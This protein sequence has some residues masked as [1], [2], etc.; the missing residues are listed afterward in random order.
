MG[1]GID[2]G[3]SGLKVVRLHRTLRGFRLIGA[4]R[5]TLPTDADL[6]SAVPQALRQILARTNPGLGVVGLGG[7][8][9]NLQIVQQPAMPAVNYRAMMGYEMEQRR[10]GEGALY[11]DFATL[12]EPD[13]YH[14]GYLAM[15]G[16]A[17]CDY[18]DQRIAMAAG[19]G[20]DVRDAI[21]TPFALYTAYRHAYGVENGIVML[22]DIGA[23]NSDL[24][25]IRGGRLIFCRNVAAGARV[26]DSG[27]AR[28]GGLSPEEAESR[29]I[30]FANLGASAEDADPRE[31]EIRP[32]VRSGASQI[33]GTIQ[34]T[35]AFARTQLGEKDLT[36]DK[37]YVSGGGA[38]LRGLPEYL[39]SALKLPVETL[40][41]F[42]GIDLGKFSKEREL[43]ARPTDLAAA[44]GL[45][46]ISVDAK[47]AAAVLSILPDKIVARRNFFRGPAFLVAAG[48]LLAV[49]V[50]AVTTV[51]VVRRSRAA[52]ALAE[53]QLNNKAVDDRIR[54]VND[55]ETELRGLIAKRRMLD[56]HVT[57]GRGLMDAILKM[58]KILQEGVH[59]RAVRLVNLQ[60]EQ[61]NMT[62]P[63]RIVFSFPT[64]G[65]LE[66]VI[67][68]RKGTGTADP[69][70]MMIRIL[71]GSSQNE[72]ETFTAESLK[73]RV[74]VDA[75]W[76]GVQIE[77]EIDDRI[78]GTPSVVLDDLRVQLSDPSRGVAA[79]LHQEGASSRPGWQLFK[80]ILRFE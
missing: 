38:R 70:E 69:P 43:A 20:I 7:R 79:E 22:L 41:P 44:I 53:F 24:A 23:D 9:V 34:S 71:D 28:L 51:A 61:P 49:A 48:V 54:K 64:R 40:D 33:A 32:A 66:G 37:L 39:Q 47:S 46:Q 42:R 78:K 55:L 2:I 15:A 62:P 75:P 27:I 11:G 10:G 59:I 18:V 60:E 14:P 45:A 16:I 5:T 19:A 4:A 36:V 76:L 56:S 74:K 3:T 13:P 58:R 21:P 72:P 31:D 52:S 63:E 29:K 25:L 77:G 17:K 73:A 8:D 57:P 26:I 12:R 80:I 50:I 35:I 68:A 6:K 1:F 65:I 30:Q 67:P